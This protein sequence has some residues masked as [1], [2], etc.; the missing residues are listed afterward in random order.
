[1]KCTFRE[2]IDV[3]IKVKWLAEKYNRTKA[4]S[5]LSYQVYVFRRFAKK[6]CLDHT[7]PVGTTLLACTW[8]KNKHF[9]EVSWL[10]QQFYPI[11]HGTFYEL[12]FQASHEYP[13]LLTISK[14]NTCLWHCSTQW[15]NDQYFNKNVASPFCMLAVPLVS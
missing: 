15:H 10:F 7:V 9:A 4:T 11:R 12:L 5:K 1:M 14:T 8:P 6:V 2:Y 13:K 3:C